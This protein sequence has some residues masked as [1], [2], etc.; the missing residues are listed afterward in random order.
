[1]SRDIGEEISSRGAAQ[2]FSG[3]I[4]DA[5]VKESYSDLQEDNG[6]EGEE[7]CAFLWKKMRWI[8][9]AEEPDESEES[10]R[11]DG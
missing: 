6:G 11:F 4:E 10:G 1:M 9:I 7:K 8:G 5:P 2:H 3:R